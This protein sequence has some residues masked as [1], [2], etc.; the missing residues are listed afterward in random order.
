MSATSALA[1]APAAA[2]D[3]PVQTDNNETVAE[4]TA[5]TPPKTAVPEAATEPLKWLFS[6]TL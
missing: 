1:A 6:R 3:E 5:A 4:P 2:T